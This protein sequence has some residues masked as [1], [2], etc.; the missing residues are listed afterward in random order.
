MLSEF[1]I[2]SENTSMQMNT[3]QTIPIPQC[4]TLLI[5]TN[6]KEIT[7]MQHI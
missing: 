1:S 5:E 4:G 6:K 7:K 2:T 3:E